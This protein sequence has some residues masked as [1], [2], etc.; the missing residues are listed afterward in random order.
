M[1]TDKTP[2]GRVAIIHNDRHF[3]IY[4]TIFVI[5]YLI[6]FLLLFDLLHEY[7]IITILLLF[8]DN[9]IIV[10]HGYR[11]SYCVYVREHAF[12]KFYDH[13]HKDGRRDLLYSSK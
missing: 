1:V 4:V 10:V 5:C 8:S 3:A 7:F 12:Q 6:F 11:I 9:I 2:G 13:D